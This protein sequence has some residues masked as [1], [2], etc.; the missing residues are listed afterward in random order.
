MMRRSRIIA[1][2]AIFGVLAVVGG[3]AWAQASGCR[4]AQVAPDVHGQRLAR[5]DLTDEQKT[6]IK[7]LHEET[8][9]ARLESEAKIRQLEQELHG[10]MTKDEPNA[11]RVSDL[12]RK[13][14][15][16]RTEMQLSRVKL[17]MATHD[18]LTPE[19][20][21][22]LTMQGSKRARPVQRP[23]AR[24]SPS[25]RHIRDRRAGRRCGHDLGD[26]LSFGCGPCGGMRAPMKHMSGQ[27]SCG[28]CGAG[29]T[30]CRAHGE[31][32]HSG[33][34]QETRQAGCK[35][36]EAKEGGC[37]KHQKAARTGCRARGD[38]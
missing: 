23:G 8:R 21:A 30:G 12:V 3:V 5:L 28:N 14:G 17:Q 36:H 13:I 22:H 1:L 26:C 16:L 11:D 9:E 20:R 25:Q 29:Q 34:K 15:D 6:A 4:H 27:C 35:K 7:E 10:E 38:S 31:V 19:Q 2:V 24:R 32:V 37:Q 18:H 33:C